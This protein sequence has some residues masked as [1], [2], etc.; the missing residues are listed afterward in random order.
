MIRVH[1]EILKLWPVDRW[2]SSTVV[3]ALSGGPDSVA[4]LRSLHQIVQSGYVSKDTRLVVAHL[5]HRARGIESDRD[6]EFVKH[7][8]GE[9]QLETVIDSIAQ[10]DPDSSEARWRELRMFFLH[11]V[12]S[13]FKASWIATGATADDCVE[14]LLHHL[15]RGSGPAGLSGIRLQRKLSD[16][17]TLIHPLVGLWKDELLQYLKS[18]NQSY[19]ID[20]TNLGSDYMRNRIRNECIP[21]LEQFIGSDSLKRRLYTAAELIRQEHEVVEQLARQWLDSPAIR[22]GESQI[23]VDWKDIAEVPWPVLQCGLVEIW[24]RMNW[25][26]QQIGFAHWDRVRDW[27]ES[28]RTTNHPRRMQLPGPIELSIARRRVTMKSAMQ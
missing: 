13:E 20:H 26:L 23:E 14:T 9:L 6:E 25:P 16:G 28:A 3:V 2:N 7:I 12:A 11:K 24:H 5:N 17:L 4:L 1:Q 19:R 15:L 27:I 8:A 22:W 10:P 21:F 18:L